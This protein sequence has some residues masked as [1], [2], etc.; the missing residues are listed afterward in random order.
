[1]S[2]PTESDLPIC[3]ICAKPIDE[4]KDETV[5]IGVDG[6]RYHW[7]CLEKRKNEGRKPELVEEE[8]PPTAP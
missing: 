3:A 1:M 4:S 2:P 8:D 7:S 5:G 6:Q